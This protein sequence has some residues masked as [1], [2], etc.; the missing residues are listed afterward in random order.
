MPPAPC[1]SPPQVVTD[2]NGAFTRFLGMEQAAPDAAGAR[3]LRYAAVVDD[4][5]LLK[6][7][8]A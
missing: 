8:S 5:T 2:E 3:S 4:G 6:V 7:V 1:A